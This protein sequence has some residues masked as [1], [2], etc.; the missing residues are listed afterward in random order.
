MSRRAFLG[1]S[2]AVATV[3]AVPRVV[4]AVAPDRDRAE[5]VTADVAVVGAGFAGLAAALELSRRGA[6]VVVLEARSRVGGRALDI[7]LG[8]GRVV[9]LGA[10]WVH[11]AH[12]RVL[13]LARAAGVRTVAVAAPA[14]GANPAEDAG[15][16]AAL[17]RLDLM[18][19][20]VDPAA[21]WAVVNAEARDGRTLRSWMDD[22]VPAAD[23]R[24]ALTRVAQALWGMEPAEISLLYALSAIAAAGGAARLVGLAFAPPRR[25]AGGAQLV[26]D[27]LAASLGDRVHVSS[28]VRRVEHGD[29]GV[30]V[31]ARGLVV[32]AQQVVV[33]LPPAVTGAI[34]WSPKL[35]AVRRQLAQRLPM[36]SAVT[37]AGVYDRRF[38]KAARS[39]GSDDP[40]A[41]VHAVSTGAGG[42]GLLVGSLGG[43]AARRWAALPAAERRQAALSAF[44][45]RYG[46]RAARPVAYHEKDWQRSQWSAGGWAGVAPP[47]VLT[48]FGT[49][50]REPIG[51]VHWAGTETAA[52][53]TGSLEGAVQSGER[54]AAEALAALSGAV[55]RR[56]MVR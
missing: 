55:T 56:G 28:P 1:A 15:V 39:T 37:V 9:G 6:S 52:A 48:S 41:V 47:G 32:R 17:R 12:E 34:D 13:A 30:T 54:A 53:W 50:L 11:P 21:P 7:P 3:A 49:A 27:R 35:P 23:T 16:A 45:A 44:A 10:T 43:A 29:G 8:A 38:P 42:P 46:K 33:A 25:F 2:G 24:A 22:N 19:S 14:P 4:R 51:P 31:E 20:E 36:G 18:A 26:A 40:M 5:T